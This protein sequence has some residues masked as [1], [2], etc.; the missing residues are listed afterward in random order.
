MS[1]T[2]Q[3]N[4]AK[5][6]FNMVESVLVGNTVRI[7]HL[8]REMPLRGVYGQNRGVVETWGKGK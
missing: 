5:M 1:G 7:P 6:V 8:G 3:G 4:G 2:D